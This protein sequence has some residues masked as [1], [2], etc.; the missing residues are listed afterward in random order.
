MSIQNVVVDGSNLATEGRTLP[1]LTQLEEAVQAYE[2]EHPEATLIIVVDATFEHRIDAK[3]RPRLKEAE[4][5]GEVVA[6]PAGTIGRGDVFILKIAQRQGAVVLSNDSFQEFH[7]DHPWLFDEGRLVGGKPVQG[8][9]W[10]FTER[11]PVRGA[12]SR[13]ATTSKAAKETAKPLKKLAVSRPDGSTPKVGDVLTPSSSGKVVPI[14]KVRAYE[15]AKDLGLDAKSLQALAGSAGVSIAS[16]SSSLSPDEV[17][18]VRTAAALKKVR[19][20]ELAKDLSIESKEVIEV[21]KR[22]KIEVASH[23]SSLSE[24]EV[25]RIR[26]SLETSAMVADVAQSLPLKEKKGDRPR[27]KQGKARSE[28]SSKKSSAKSSKNAAKLSAKKTNAP[29][30]EAKSTKKQASPAKKKKA[31]KKASDADIANQPLDLVTFL[32]NYNVGSSLKGVVT[33]F[34]SHGA[35]IEVSLGK[36]QSFRCYARTARLGSPPPPRARDVLTK[37]DTYKFKVVAIDAARR[38][39]ELELA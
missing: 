24:A 39:A 31:S 9:G 17:E 18:A 34:T 7:G 33:S 10:I 19:V 27:R 8:V 38:V 1:S 29:T 13:A 4:L 2:E 30:P 25:G 35:M 32:A 11:T 28:E 26:T 6:P 15:L 36:S 23:A 3:E 37:G 14:E 16:H 21:A 5:H 22:L 12:K 20:H